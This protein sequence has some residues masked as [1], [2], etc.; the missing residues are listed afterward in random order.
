MG[1][2]ENLTIIVAFGGGLLSFFSPCV[3]PLVPSYLSFITG[4]SVNDFREPDSIR[5]LHQKVFLN[6]LFFVLG[7]SA[8]FITLGVSFSYLG[9]F[10]ARHQWTIQKISGLIII[11]FGL[12]I[13]GVFRFSFLMRSKEF[14]PLKTKPVGYIG[15]AIV[16]ISFGAA[17]TPCIGPI[18]G[19]ILVLAGSAKEMKEG[20]ILLTAYSMGLAIPF[21]LTAWASGSFLKIFRKL[22][23]LVRVIHIAGG[24]FLIIVGILIFT[25]YFTVL[26]S[27]FIGLTPS[28]I[29]EKI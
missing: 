19:S 28:W 12:Y 13:A 26:N 22:G 20:M 1:L 15:S 25:G 24:I 23:K 11:I 18:L 21:L 6:A 3:F 29:L 27:L 5:H 17:W 14:L 16:G 4:I 2:T 7:F 8:I 10:F 9:M